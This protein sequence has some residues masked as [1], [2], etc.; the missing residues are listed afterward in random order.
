MGLGK[1]TFKGGVSV[2]EYKELTCNNPI[3]VLK[4]PEIVYI[5]LHQH[6]GAPCEPIVDVGDVVKVG[7]KIGS[8]N[9]FVSS[10]IHSSVSG[11]VKELSTIYAPNGIK[12]KCVV[13][14]NDGKDEMVDGIEEKKLESL[15]RETIITLFKEMG[16][17]GMGGACFPTHVK[18]SPPEDKKIDVLIVNGAECEP[19]I[20][21]DHRLMLEY[22]RD[23]ISGIKVAMKAL[24][25]EKAYIGIE[26]NKQDAIEA[27][28]KEL[29]SET[30]IVVAS[31]KTKYP[32][33]DE[34]RIINAITGRKVPLGGLPMDVGCVVS[35]VATIKAINDAVLKGKP[36]YERVVTVTGAVNNPKNLLVKIGTP[37]ENLIEA[38]GGFKD[39]P[40]KVIVG[41]PMM[42]IAQ[43]TLKTPIVKGSNGLL[44]KSMKEIKNE[45][46]YPCIKCGKCIDVCPSRLEPLYLSSYSLK[47]NYG[48]CDELNA[49][50]CVE[51]GACS[52]IC[53]AKRPL[54]ESIK[55]AKREITAKRKKS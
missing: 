55:K 41:G 20:T 8:S 19:Y 34:K 50:A 13:I 29:G 39:K 54:A 28:K 12:S 10:S 27:M 25:V 21:A 44:V 11:I 7:Q 45:E 36:L 16:V 49:L 1:L 31:L 14:E 9:A 42:G 33:G 52:Y 17:V 46:V 23:I 37:I 30:K 18:Y 43:F 3:E 24:N 26:D 40:G 15:N 2:P 6:T 51:C 5:P 38:C 32:Q 22:T 48:K 47:D 4:S 35:N 53:P